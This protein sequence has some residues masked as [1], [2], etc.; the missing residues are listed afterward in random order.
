MFTFQATLWRRED[1]LLYISSVLDIPE[2]ALHLTIPGNIKDE[3]QRKKFLQVDFNIAENT[4]GQR[5][6]REVLG[7]KIHLAWPRAHSS[8][9][10]VMLC[11]W[12]Y[13]PTAVEKGKLGEWV[14]EFAKREGFP[15]QL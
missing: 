14:Y 11:P 9:N 10:A 2:D 5:K 15:I 4:F 13:R 3:N 8:P 1:Y 6:F 12:P 7:H